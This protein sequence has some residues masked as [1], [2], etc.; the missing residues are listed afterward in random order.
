MKK[1]IY[2]Y[3]IQIY[4]NGLDSLIVKYFKT[5]SEVLSFLCLAN[6]PLDEN[7]KFRG[8]FSQIEIYDIRS[9]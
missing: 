7:Y 2:S 6:N 1:D 8:D 3:A 4:Y 9:F 5:Y